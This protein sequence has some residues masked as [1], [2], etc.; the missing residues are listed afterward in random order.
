MKM[1]FDAWLKMETERRKTTRERE[2][3]QQLSEIAR[4]H[5]LAYQAEIAPLIT[6]LGNIAARKPPLPLPV[7]VDVKI[8]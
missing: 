3:E 6:E 5:Q 2:I 8:F 1:D 4:R 7:N